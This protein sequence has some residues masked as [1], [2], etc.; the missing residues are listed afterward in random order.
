M[1]SGATA[2]LFQVI[3]TNPM[4]IIKI[5][6]QMQSLKPLAEQQSTMEVIQNLG[7][8]GAYQGTVSTLIRD[9]PFSFII[10]P[11]YANL[12]KAFANSD[13]GETSFF[14]NLAAGCIAAGAASGAVTPMD[15]VKTRLQVSGAKEKYGDGIAA[16]IKCTKDVHAEGGIS[17][18]FRGVGP[19]MGVVSPLFGIALVAFEVQKGIMVKNAMKN[20]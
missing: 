8:R 3:A 4:E 17:T 1:L 5:R 18:F 12:R 15:V 19:R 14:G 11:L 7:I 20:S 16:L 10:F 2:G 9:I 13:T 6:M